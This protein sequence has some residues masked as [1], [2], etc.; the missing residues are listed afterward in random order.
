MNLRFQ[1]GTLV[2]GLLLGA[3]GLLL[4][5]TRPTSKVIEQRSSEIKVET[6]SPDIVSQSFLTEL[7]QREVN[8]ELPVVVEP[9]Q[10]YTGEKRNPFG[11]P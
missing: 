11:T 9:P 1:V 3:Y 5:R 6:V 10:T 4:W 7:R 8:G 2:L